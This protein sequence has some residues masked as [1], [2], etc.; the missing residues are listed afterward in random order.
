VEWAKEEGIGDQELLQRVNDA[1]KAHFN[2]KVERYGE[3]MMRMAEKRILLQTLDR[4]WKDH[5]LSL[6]HLR[7]GIYLRG[8]GQRD[9]L[10]EY[11]QEAFTLFEQL[12]FMLRE[13]VVSG[14]SHIEIH[15][16]S[17]P[18]SFPKAIL[19]D[20]PSVL[21]DETAQSSFSQQKVGRNDPCPCGSGK[22]FKHCHG[23][24][25]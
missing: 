7:Q 22:K 6:D 12:L 16:A 5:L 9:P 23:A 14:I 3:P 10:N 24:L 20:Q 13:Q 19:S 21:A 8:Y 4:L 1:T 15:I 11:K 2:S 25:K 17:P 18:Q